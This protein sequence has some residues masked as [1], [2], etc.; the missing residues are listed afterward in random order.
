MSTTMK[1]YCQNCGRP[2][3]VRDTACGDCGAAPSAEQLGMVAALPAPKE[4]KNGLAVASLVVSLLGL[5][6]VPLVG[7]VAAVVMGHLAR[8][9]MAAAPQDGDSFALSGIAIGYLGIAG[10]F[11]FALLFFWLSRVLPAV[12]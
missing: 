7:S 1:L 11:G 3:D 12:T 6:L 2:M 5:F 4:G 9:Q 10:W 8:R